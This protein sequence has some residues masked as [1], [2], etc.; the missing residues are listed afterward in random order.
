[1]HILPTLKFKAA[2]PKMP[3]TKKEYFHTGG[4]QKTS[5]EARD[6][7]RSPLAS[8]HFLNKGRDTVYL[9]PTTQRN[10]SRWVSTQ[11]YIS[12]FPNQSSPVFPAWSWES[13]LRAGTPGNW[14]IPA[15]KKSYLLC[16]REVQVWRL[17]P[18][19][20]LSLC[21]NYLRSECALA[22]PLWDSRTADETREGSPVRRRAEVSEQMFSV[23]S[24]Q[25]DKQE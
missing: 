22:R 17:R 2:S 7:P 8:H 21:D 18:S 15:W 6:V 1:M 9:C 3:A 4:I 24:D 10:C 5:V 16:P 14:G 13:R 11:S 19:H 23:P 25:T 20:R 12:V